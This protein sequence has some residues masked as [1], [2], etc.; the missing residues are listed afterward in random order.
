[1][2]PF[3]SKYNNLT[4]RIITG[5]LGA[6]VIIF[7]VVYSDLTYFVIFLCI[8]ALALWEF[9]ALTLLDGMIPQKTF[10]TL[11]GIAIF[12]LSFFI[13]RGDIPPRYYYLF[14]LAWRCTI[15]T[16]ASMYVLSTWVP[17]YINTNI[18]C[19]YVRTV[20]TPR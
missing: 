20:R 10:G 12:S 4:Q 7:C 18:L 9:Y 19:L 6:A 15:H 2:I 8:S 3:L 16:G 1:M 17:H 13:E 11:C 5:L 14:F